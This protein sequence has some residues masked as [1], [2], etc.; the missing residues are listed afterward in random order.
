MDEEE[1]DEYVNHMYITDVYKENDPLSLLRTEHLNDV[2][3]EKHLTL[4]KN[5][6]EIFF[7]EVENLTFTHKIKHEIKT[8]NNTAVYTKSYVYPQVDQREVET[9]I[10]DMLVQEII[11]QSKFTY[12]SPIWVVPKKGDASGKMK[13]RIVVPKIHQLNSI[14]VD[15]KFPI[16]NIDDILDTLGKCMYFSTI[17]P[18]KGFHQIEIE[19][20]DIPKTAFSTG[21]KRPSYFPASNERYSS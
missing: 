12:S 5:D 9:Q 4:L 21:K 16:P 18:A 8:T 13:G 20:K 19:E 10:R 1:L 11:R 2:E 17:D 7:Q 3:N 15:D 14:I 6:Q